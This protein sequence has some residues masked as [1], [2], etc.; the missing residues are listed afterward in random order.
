MHFLVGSPPGAAVGKVRLASNT[1]HK[2][3]STVV[4]SCETGAKCTL[5]MLLTV[6]LPNVEET[7]SFFC[8]IVTFKTS[9]I[10]QQWC[11]INL[12]LV[13][14]NKTLRESVVTGVGNV[15][16]SN[17]LSVSFVSV[18]FFCGHPYYHHNASK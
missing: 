16:I 10:W 1:A 18:E 2:K 13:N 12:I 8:E 17:L 3:Q 14:R 9:P 7:N 4:V 11:T 15:S 6:C 5:H